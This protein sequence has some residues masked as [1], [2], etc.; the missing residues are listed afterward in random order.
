MASDFSSAVRWRKSTRSSQHENSDC[1]EL[2]AVEAQVAI[3]DSKDPN[4]PRLMLT[5]SQWNA[6]SGRL[7][8]CGEA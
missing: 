1:V 5:R 4:G 3:R 8:D 6:L 7:K 2:A